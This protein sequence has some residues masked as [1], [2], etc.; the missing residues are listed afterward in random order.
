M[1]HV[2]DELGVGRTPPWHGGLGIYTHRIVARGQY[3]SAVVIG[4]VA[5]AV[6]VVRVVAAAI[7]LLASR[8]R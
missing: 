1:N 2:L 4:G 5:S 8:G 3:S 6:V 7:S